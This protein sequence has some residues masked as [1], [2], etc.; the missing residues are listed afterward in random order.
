MSGGFK[1]NYLTIQRTG[2]ETSL[3]FATNS[4]HAAPLTIDLPEYLTKEDS[5]EK[6]L[7]AIREGKKI[8]DSQKII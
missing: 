3:D 6:L 8:S 2:S 1:N 5:A 4:V 7:L